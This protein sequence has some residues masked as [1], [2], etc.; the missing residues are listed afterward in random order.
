MNDEPEK[1]KNKLSFTVIN[2][3]ARSLCPKINSLLDCFCDLRASVAVITETWLTDGETLEED[4]DGLCQGAGIG[5][6]CRNREVNERGFSHG[7]VAVA[8]KSSE[9]SLKKVKLHNPKNYEVLM[10]TGMLARCSRRLVVVACYIP[11]N[12]TVPRGKGALSFIAGA[13]TEAKR[14]YDDPLIVLAGDFNQWKVEE[15]SEDFPDLAEAM[16]GPTRGDHCIDRIFANLGTF[17]AAGTVPPLETDP[18]P[19]AQSKKSDHMIGYITVEIPRVRP[20]TMMNYSY[21]YYSPEGDLEYGQWLAGHKWTEVLRASGS[22]AKTEIYQK[23]VTA[24]LDRIFPLITVR[25]RST[26][27]HGTIG[28]SGNAWLRRGES[29]GERGGRRSGRR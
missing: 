6:V 20:F 24:A 7:G 9:M 21:R 11:P 3:N 25:R 13:V 14:R 10:V 5:L 19:E 23:E 28:G 18:S 4:I 8:F 17:K 15:V 22:N 12:Y 27:P 16:I 26:D 2:T 1:D 29:T